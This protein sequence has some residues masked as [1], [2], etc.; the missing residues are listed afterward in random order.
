MR[1]PALL[2]AA[3]TLRWHGFAPG[4]AAC[5]NGSANTAASA[6]VIRSKEQLRILGSPGGVARNTPRG[7][8]GAAAVKI[9]P[10][11]YCL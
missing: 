7:L 4:A 11:E 8:G 5:Y 6:A 10:P 3:K 9:S 2:P 1:R